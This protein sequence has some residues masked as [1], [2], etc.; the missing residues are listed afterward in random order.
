M[1]SDTRFLILGFFPIKHQ[2][3]AANDVESLGYVLADIF[4]KALCKNQC[5]NKRGIDTQLKFFVKLVEL[6]AKHYKRNDE[7]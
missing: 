4:E 3:I 7:H 1:D 2:Y 5:H 6:E